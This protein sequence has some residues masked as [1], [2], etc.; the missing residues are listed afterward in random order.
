[1]LRGPASLWPINATWR[2]VLT[3]EGISKTKDV[4]LQGASLVDVGELIRNR[5]FSTYSN[6]LHRT[7]TSTPQAEHNCRL[8]TKYRH[9]K[10]RMRQKWVG[11]E[12]RS[13]YRILAG[14]TGGRLRLNIGVRAAKTLPAEPLTAKGASNKVSLSMF[15]RETWRAAKRRWWQQQLILLKLR[16]VCHIPIDALSVDIQD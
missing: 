16:N 15:G 1:M 13:L 11:V 3:S 12:S 9:T 8:V 5:K 4:S 6:V 2:R 10:C 14:W 7:L